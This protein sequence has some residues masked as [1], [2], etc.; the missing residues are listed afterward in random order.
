MPG[1]SK[2]QAV[3]KL[4]KCNVKVRDHVKELEVLLQYDTGK[5]LNKEALIQ[6][7][8]TVYTMEIDEQLK[9]MENCAEI[10]GEFISLCKAEKKRREAQH[11]LKRVEKR[12][13]TKEKRKLKRLQTQTA[14]N[15]YAHE[16]S[17]EDG[18]MD[19]E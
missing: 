1:M 11:E 7:R 19:A 12:G 14:N 5:V 6:A 15:P 16:N 10:I 17:E 18:E 13:A 9:G 3:E 8:K 2:S 4:T